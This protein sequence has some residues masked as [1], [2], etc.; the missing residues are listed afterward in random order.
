MDTFPLS[1]LDLDGGKKDEIFSLMFCFAND[2]IYVIILLLLHVILLRQNINSC[3]P[4]VWTH[5]G[6][7]EFTSVR[8]N[9]PSN[10][11]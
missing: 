6:D 10:E 11:T 9:S 8:V 1:S 3:A 4:D 5:K 7:R 2:K